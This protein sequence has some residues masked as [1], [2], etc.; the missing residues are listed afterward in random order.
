LFAVVD[1]GRYGTIEQIRQRWPSILWN[2]GEI[3]AGT[4]GDRSFYVTDPGARLCLARYRA[5]RHIAFRD[6]AE[7][8]APEA[9]QDD[10]EEDDL[11]ADEPLEAA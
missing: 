5:D 9:P 2:D 11:R 10:P 7:P 1:G 8:E 3:A 6:L 4:E